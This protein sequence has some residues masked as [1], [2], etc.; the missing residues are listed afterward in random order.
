MK[1]LQESTAVK[2]LVDVDCTHRVLLNEEDFYDMAWAYLTRA[3]AEGVVHIEAFFDPQARAAY[4]ISFHLIMCFLRDLDEADAMATLEVSLPFKELITAVG[5]DSSEAGHPPEKFERVYARARAEGY[6]AVAHA[7][8]EGPAHNISTSLDLL[9]VARIDHGVRCLEDPLLVQRLVRDRVPLTVCPVSNTALQLFPS[10]KEHNLK[11]MLREGLVVTVN[12]DDPAYFNA[13]I[14]DN[15][16]QAYLHLDF[17]LED[18]FV[19]AENSFHASFLG[20]DDK[21]AMLA[22][23]T[24]YRA[25]VASLLPLPPPVEAGVSVGVAVPLSLS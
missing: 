4:G 12:S 1:R 5:L 13:Y 19:L 6:L 22:R 8:E 14:C 18:L 15:F 23:V 20:A 10:M 24:A 7:G 21:A 16:L 2:Q 3:H 25:H 9:N 11:Q 17:L